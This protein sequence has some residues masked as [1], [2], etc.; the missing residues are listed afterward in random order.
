MYLIIM[1][2]QDNPYTY[3]GAITI[4]NG[5]PWYVTSLAKPTLFTNEKD[6][7][8]TIKRLEKSRPDDSFSVV[9]VD[10]YLTMTNQDWSCEWL[11]Q[12]RQE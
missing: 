8:R 12:M 5:H 1:N 6:A 4:I 9:S 2:P 3:A 7:E 10:L 11:R